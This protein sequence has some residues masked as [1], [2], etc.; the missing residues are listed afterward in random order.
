MPRLNQ[1]SSLVRILLTLI[2]N[3]MQFMKNKN[4]ASQMDRINLARTNNGIAVATFRVTSFESFQDVV[5]RQ[6]GTQSVV[7]VV[8]T[9][10][11]R[12]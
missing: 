10:K 9:L 1:V 5:V 8:L 3:L 6:I 7:A 4:R 11:D 12:E 2:L